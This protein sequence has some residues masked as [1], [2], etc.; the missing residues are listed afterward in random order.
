MNKVQLAHIG[1]ETVAFVG[2]LYYTIQ[3][4]KRLQSEIDTLKR[5]VRGVAKHSS[6]R[7]AEQEKLLREHQSLL[8]GKP[9]N[10]RRPLPRVNPL[11]R[12]EEKE[13]SSPPPPL[14]EEEDEEEDVDRLLSKRSQGAQ[15][16]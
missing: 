11:P 14:A 8:K 3:E 6:E 12:E 4:N 7:F 15:S 13:E 2:L 16:S 9:R 1:V 5:E 10:S